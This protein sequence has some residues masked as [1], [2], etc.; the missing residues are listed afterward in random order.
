[1]DEKALQNIILQ[2]YKKNKRDLPWRRTYD[3]YKILISEVMLQ[4]TRVERVVPKYREFLK[5]FSTARKLAR[6]KPAEVIKI[7][8]GLGYNRRALF[9]ILV[10][11]L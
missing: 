3:P 1:M 4:Q 7:W 6:A 5:A 11:G 8:K 9:Y 10:Q 2:W